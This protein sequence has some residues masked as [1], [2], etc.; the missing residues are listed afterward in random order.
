M[1]HNFMCSTLYVTLTVFIAHIYNMR[2]DDI[3]KVKINAKLSC[4]WFV[5]VRYQR[6]LQ[7]HYR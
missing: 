1:I 7:R 4:S 6:W 3:I 2:S 5:S